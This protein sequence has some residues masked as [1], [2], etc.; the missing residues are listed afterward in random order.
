MSFHCQMFAHTE[1][2]WKMKLLQVW[3]IGSKSYLFSIISFL[4]FFNSL[5]F[6]ISLIVLVLTSPVFC[7]K[8]VSRQHI[9]AVPSAAITSSLKGWSQGNVN[10]P[11]ELSSFISPTFLSWQL[12]IIFLK[13]SKSICAVFLVNLECGHIMQ[14]ALQAF[15]PHRIVDPIDAAENVAGL[16]AGALT[17]RFVSRT[18][19]GEKAARECRNQ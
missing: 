10:L 6:Q 19:H 15:V 4:I 8:L 16:F 3:Q 2:S 12:S 13:S 5:P 1:F 7:V 11:A 18:R 14:F 17:W 9:P